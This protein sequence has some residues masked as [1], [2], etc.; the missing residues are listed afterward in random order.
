MFFLQKTP[1][2]PTSEKYLFLDFETSQSNKIH[3]PIYC[4]IIYSIKED[5]DVL[6]WKEHSIG[7]GEDISDEVGEFL[8]SDSF[9]R[10]LL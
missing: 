8:F 9:R 6:T 5:D 10:Y 1:F 2:K 3:I 7:L 4:H